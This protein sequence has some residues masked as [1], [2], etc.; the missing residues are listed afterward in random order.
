MDARVSSE[1]QEQ[2]RTVEC[3]L[4]RISCLDLS[5]PEV[6]MVGLGDPKQGDL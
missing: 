3:Y 1:V 5:V 2:L 6:D 4:R